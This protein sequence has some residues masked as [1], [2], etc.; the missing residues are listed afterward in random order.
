M[1]RELILKSRA[2]TYLN[3]SVVVMTDEEYRQYLRNVIDFNY[4]N[5]HTHNPQVYAALIFNAPVPEGFDPYEWWLTT[6]VGPESC[7]R[8]IGD[9][10]E[11]WLLSKGD[12]WGEDI[13]AFL[14]EF[15]RTWGTPLQVTGY[16]CA[17]TL[18]RGRLTV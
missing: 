17:E 2:A 15:Q 11:T 1:S 12:E 4:P 5:L 7:S 16:A 3:T 9:I 10:R 14:I 8:D 6:P 13:E 18:R